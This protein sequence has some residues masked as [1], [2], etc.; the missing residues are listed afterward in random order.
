MNIVLPGLKLVHELYLSLK[1]N[2]HG[3]KGTQ[4]LIIA[5]REMSGIK[6]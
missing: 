6:T 3:S 2:N 4:A 5:L 1:A